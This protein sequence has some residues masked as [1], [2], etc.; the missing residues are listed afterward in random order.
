MQFY[1]LSGIVVT[2]FLSSL[3]LIKK[4]KTP[5]DYLLAAWLFLLGAHLSLFNLV[6]TG[7]YPNW[8]YLLGVELAMPLLHGPFL[9]LYTAE[10]TGHFPAKH[11]WLLHF[12][13]FCAANL[14]LA[15]FFTLPVSAKIAV[16]D[17]AGQG[18]ETQ[19]LFIRYAIY[20]SGIVYIILSLLLLRKHR[21]RIL[22]AYSETARISLNWLRY[23]IIGVSLIW[24]PVLLSND[25]VIFALVVVFVLFVGYFGIRQVGILDTHF[26]KMAVPVETATPEPV[27]Y[28]KTR[29]PQEVT[30]QLHQQ[31]VRV[32]ETE[33]PYMN[34]ELTLGD[35]AKMLQVHPNN[36]SQ[37]INLVE[38]K[39]FY[40]YINHYRIQAF[41]ALAAQSDQQQFTLL[42]LA[43]ECGF[44]SKASF[45][46]NF[47]KYRGVTPT[48]YLQ[49]RKKD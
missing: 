45:N 6:S 38:E 34:P 14:L 46:R 41:E 28:E 1:Y 33:K 25:H 42:S 18:Y 47:K 30:N 43:M 35:L 8:P 31:L 32:M 7:A 23:L 22:Q 24:L 11:R 15:P 2:F 48:E 13:P 12:L 39:N 37:V 40:D 5:A 4:H 16:Y 49:Q 3:L 26:G 19:L 29:L 20:L 10:L 27:R 9:Y 21:Q 44:N 36:L 17:H